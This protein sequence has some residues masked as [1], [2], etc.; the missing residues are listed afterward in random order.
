MRAADL[1]W[2]TEDFEGA[3]RFFLEAAA[4]GKAAAGI[5]KIAMGLSASGRFA[6]L[7]NWIDRLPPAMVDDDAWLSFYRILGSRAR[8]RHRTVET[9]A[10]ALVRFRQAG[11][12]RGELMSLG[13]LIETAVFLGHPPTALHRWLDAARDLLATVSSN[14][15]FAFAKTVLWMQVAF[16]YIAGS[17]DLQQ[18][19][20]AG[21][22][23]MLL[24][25]TIADDT[26]T[27]NA[28]IIYVFGLALGGQYGA[29]QRAMDGIRDR[30][31]AA[32]PEYRVLRNL[33][34]MDL[35]LS[36]GDLA[37]A[38]A[39]FD[40]NQDV[41]DRFGLLFLY[42]LHVDL[43]GLLQIQQRR[44]DDVG[45]TA[46]HL[47]DVATLAANP[48][49]NG[50]AYRLRALKDYHQ[51]RFAPARRWAEKAVAV[52]AQ[53]LGESI[54]LCRGRLILGMAAYHLGD[55]TTARRAL[56]TAE[57]FAGRAASH[58]AL[59]EARLGL[60]LTAAAAG[61]A[62]QAAAY[63][64]SALAAAAAKEAVALPVLAA[65][66][67]NA[68]LKTAPSDSSPAPEACARRLMARATAVPPAA[69]PPAASPETV[70]PDAAVHIHT[71]GGFFVRRRDG[72]RLGDGDWAGNRQKLL[73]KAIVVN[74]CREIP[75]DILMDAL[76]PE[77]DREAALKRFKVTLHR[78]R[79]MLEPE[80]DRPA[81][82]SC[83]VLRDNLVSLDMAI[84][85]VDVNEFLAACDAIRQ[86]RSEDDE[87]RL[88]GA[89]RRAIE[90]YRGDFLPEALYLHWAE[91]RRAALREQYIAVRLELAGLLE[92]SGDLNAAVRQCAA[93]I[94]A[95]PLAEKAHQQRIRLLLVQGRRSAALK[96]YRELTRIL[97]DELDTVPDPA[98]THL[99]AAL[100]RP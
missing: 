64:Q 9:Y 51:G 42:P 58:A 81:G 60:S 31:A 96:T 53:C 46:R 22:N 5:K 29:A 49:Y 16:G 57:A 13:Y 67:I 100:L 92:Q 71:L 88:I 61:E 79:R 1:A 47:T 94:Q 77:I 48:L 37:Q 27:V 39:L 36:Q 10:A 33:V 40:A 35:A 82:A 26:L 43:S 59:I 45:R 44:F 38:Q 78:L 23:A 52:I 19:L 97:A 63:R 25:G 87:P 75:K 93:V 17:G 98:T 99:V 76:W 3:I 55:L 89:C 8:S 4:Y 74:G 14:R 84:C 80:T 91:T 66:D 7:S 62:S 86:L 56:A 32:D 50:L 21:R 54:H 83:I 12:P 15:Y 70:A 2:Q 24:A 28:T 90:I 41:I 65:A 69:E 6:D 20:S 30:V 73:L 95:D 68:A 85:R 72:T 11:D 18:G 34:R